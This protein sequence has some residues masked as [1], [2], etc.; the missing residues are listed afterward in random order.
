M[1]RSLL[2]G[3]ALGAVTRDDEAHV[4]RLRRHHG[5]RGDEVVQP[6]HRVEPP[7][8]SHAEARGQPRRGR[9]GPR[10]RRRARSTPVV[11]GDGARR[12]HRR[13]AHQRVAQPARGRG[14]GDAGARHDPI[15]QEPRRLVEI[16]D[17][18]RARWR[19]RAAGERSRHGAAEVHLEQ[20][21]LQH[22]HPLRAHQAGDLA[23]PTQ[24][25]Q[26]PTAG[27]ARATRDPRRCASSASHPLP[28]AAM[29]ARW[30][31]AATAEACMAIW[32]SAPP[33]PQFSIR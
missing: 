1:P 4:W 7:H 11:D 13:A 12:R 21:G 2:E 33:W 25:S 31:S 22:V 10:L 26:L 9:T 27:R 29:S 5:R 6:F 24:R 30:P 15:G 19:P 16:I 17:P 20:V 8:R 14:E 28:G 23:D 3:G 18:A 32:A